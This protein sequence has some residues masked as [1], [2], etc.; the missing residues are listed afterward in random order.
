MD[1]YCQ[2]TCELNACPELS[3]SCLAYISDFP[4][5]VAY[6]TVALIRR[7]NARPKS[8]D[9]NFTALKGK[10]TGQP[11]ERLITIQHI[12]IKPQTHPSKM[13]QITTRN[14]YTH[15]CSNS[16]PIYQPFYPYIK[17]V[18]RN[19]VSIF[20]KCKN[21]HNEVQQ[22]LNLMKHFFPNLR[23]LTYRVAYR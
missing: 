9:V 11:Q 7:D 4:V 13:P 19:S 12:L 21:V 1:G 14:T 16:I 18:K 3:P 15:I 23:D 17:H 22:Y 10:N 8:F 2:L 6:S 5:S 20:N